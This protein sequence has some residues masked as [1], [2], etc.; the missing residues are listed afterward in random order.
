MSLKLKLGGLVFIIVLLFIGLM[1]F[2]NININQLENITLKRQAEQSLLNASKGLLI[3]KVISQLDVTTQHT[4]IKE[5]SDDISSMQNI[6]NN[7]L[8]LDNQSEILHYLNDTQVDLIAIDLLLQE[9]SLKLSKKQELSQQD[10]LKLQQLEQLAHKVEK[11]ASVYDE[12]LNAEESRIKEIYQLYTRI[13]IGIMLIAI[14]IVF[15]ILYFNILNPVASLARLTKEVLRGNYQ[16]KIPV[17]SR[18]ELG[19]LA[20]SFNLMTQRLQ[21]S[22]TTLDSQNTELK[23]LSKLK[24]E[25]LANTSHELR[26]PLNGIIGIAESLI[27][28]VTGKLPEKT[29]FNLNMIVNSGKR[30][31]ALIN[32]ILDFSKL[33]HKNFE[34][35]LKPIG[36]QEIV[37]MVLLLS[38]PLVAG[39]SVELLNQIDSKLPTV[40]ADENRLQQILHN[41]L[42]N[43]IKFTETGQITVSAIYEKSSHQMQNASGDEYLVITIADTGI[44]HFRR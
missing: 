38:K 3:G 12:Y 22:F 2:F 35:Q 34:L 41:L 5:I 14:S 6:I 7:S 42:G 36:L 17:K 19:Q 18:D 26:T 13:S 21:D 39:K 44:R 9:L 20:S 37:D 1:L 30:L 23:R 16:F 29:Q 15:L 33:K 4:V 40:L 31:S 43:A 25:F 8:Q 11:L 24:D 28:G 10:I 32:D 27:D